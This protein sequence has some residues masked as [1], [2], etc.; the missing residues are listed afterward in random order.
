VGFEVFISV[1]VSALAIYHSSRVN[2]CKVKRV[3]V[4][5]SCA[6]QRFHQLLHYTRKSVEAQG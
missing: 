3:F 5:Q 1:L 4:S 2:A 6:T